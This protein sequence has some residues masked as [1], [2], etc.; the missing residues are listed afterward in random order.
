M[1]STLFI[2]AEFTAIK[3]GHSMKKE[4]TG[5]MVFEYVQV[6]IG[7][8]Q[9]PGRIPACYKLL[10]TS[11]RLQVT[12]FRVRTARRRNCTYRFSFLKTLCVCDCTSL[13]FSTAHSLTLRFIVR[14]PSFTPHHPA[15]CNLQP[16]TFYIAPRSFRNFSEFAFTFSGGFRESA[17]LKF[18]IAFGLSPFV[19]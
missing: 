6:R 10:V 15:T 13:L 11:Y 5:G 8:H 7:E 1:A 9:P 12:G 16:A 18:L 4:N 17:F 2:C 14:P 3:V 19:A